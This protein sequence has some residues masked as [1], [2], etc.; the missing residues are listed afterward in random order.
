MN[1]S[2]A[3]FALFLAATLSAR[4]DWVI[5]QNSSTEGQAK[6]ITLK[7]KGDLAR[8]N[9]GSDI[10]ALLGAD[11]ITML[12]HQQKMMM[13]MDKERLKKTM[14]LAAK[15]GVVH[16]GKT[17]T[18]PTATGRREKLGKWDTEIYTWAGDGGNGTF[19]VAKDFPKAT[20]INAISEKM[21]KVMGSPMSSMA[22]RAT[23]FPGMVVKSEVTMMGRTIVT[24]LVSATEQ[25][26]DAKEFTA[27]EGYQEMKMPMLPGGAPK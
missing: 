14:E 4:A 11:G 20:E 25:E 18:K 8:V 12:M 27:P 19:W 17:P 21:S 13:R 6:E 26:V 22:P 16:N 7:I 1:K 3:I 15:L 2:M 23:D 9:M 10:S 24:T 5:V